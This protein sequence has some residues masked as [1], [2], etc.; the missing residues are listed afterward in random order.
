MILV[1][2]NKKRY[3]I[4]IVVFS[5]PLE[6]FWDI[7]LNKCEIIRNVEKEINFLLSFKNF[8]KKDFDNYNTIIIF[9]L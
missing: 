1:N 6:G 2:N 9:F 4:W 3:F 8:N 7:V 5:F